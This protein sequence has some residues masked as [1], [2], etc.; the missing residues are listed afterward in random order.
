VAAHYG[1][2]VSGSLRLLELRG[3]LGVAGDAVLVDDV[4]GLAPQ[5]D[6]PPDQL[7]ECITATPPR[8]AI[9]T[10]LLG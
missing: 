4:T 2:I 9:L 3:G 6:Q 8:Q 7:A 1:Q 5:G 10:D